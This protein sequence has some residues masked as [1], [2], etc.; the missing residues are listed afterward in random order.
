MAQGDWLF[1]VVANK[2]AW[3]YASN[4]QIGE[5]EVAILY[6]SGSWGVID[7]A[8]RGNCGPQGNGVTGTD[9]I[10]APGLPEGSLLC[11]T[12]DGE[13]S[14]FPESCMLTTSIPGYLYFIANDY[15]E[16]GN[17]SGFN[18]NTGSL[19]VEIVIQPAHAALSKSRVKQIKGE[20]VKVPHV[21]Q[22]R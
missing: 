5:G 4:V 18:D 19:L 22:V 11:K 21:L 10:I 20:P 3:Q 7:P 14:A 9:E 12:A 17:G 16:T 2:L 8:H 6:A 1:T 13:V 15:V